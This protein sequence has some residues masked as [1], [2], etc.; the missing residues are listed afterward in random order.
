MAN[1]FEVADNT[2]TA[3]FVQSGPIME[4]NALP[5]VLN[6]RHVQGWNEAIE[7]AAQICD[8]QAKKQAQMADGDMERYRKARAWD[9]HYLAAR[10]RELK[11]ECST[12]AEEQGG[13]K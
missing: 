7:A 8:D 11:I 13:S 4:Q 10:I 2:G 9:A 6:R 5:A 3:A 1:E 12:A